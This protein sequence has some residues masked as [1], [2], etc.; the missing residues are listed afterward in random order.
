M[1]TYEQSYTLHHSEPT[2]PTTF[3]MVTTIWFPTCIE[4]RKGS[5]S[6][7]LFAQIRITEYRPLVIRLH[8][9]NRASTSGSVTQAVSS[10]PL[11]Y[12]MNPMSIVLSPFVI[13][14]SG[15]LSDYNNSNDS[16]PTTSHIV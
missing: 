9:I 3:G 13:H 5:C 14:M 4:T 11:L 16:H 12:L 2:S 7:S 1:D 15:N 6:R 8:K 10:L